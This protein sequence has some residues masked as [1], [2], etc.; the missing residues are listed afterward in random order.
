MRFERDPHKAESNFRKH[1]IDIELAELVFD[2]SLHRIYPDRVE[3]SEERFIAIGMVSS[4]YLL[5]VF[6]YH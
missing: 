1:G 2:D 6:V 4:E 3:L 5:V